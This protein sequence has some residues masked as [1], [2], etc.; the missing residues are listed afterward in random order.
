MNFRQKSVLAGML[1]VGLI[2]TMPAALSAQNEERRA[3]LKIEGKETL[4]LRVLSRAFSSLY[5]D[6]VVSSS[7]IEENLPAFQS[8]YVYGKITP[9]SDL[10]TATWYEVGSDNKGTVRGW[11][12]SDD[13]FEWKQTMCLSY[14][15]PENRQPVLMF[16]SRE[17]LEELTSMTDLERQQAVERFYADIEGGQIPADFPVVTVEPKRAVDISKEFYLLPILEF[18]EIEI[19][20]REGRLLKLAAV[21]GESADA[22]ESSDIRKN[23]DF[24][25]KA[26]LDVNETDVQAL[27]KIGVDVVWVM[28]TTNSMMPYIL[29]TLKVVEDA[30]KQISANTELAETIRFG[31]W[32][33][34][35]SLEIPGID[36]NVNNYTTDLQAIDEFIPTLQ[37]VNVTTVGSEGYA[38]DVFSGIASAVNETN[39]TPDAI[40]LVILVGDAPAHETDHKWNASG[41]N[42]DTLRIIANDRNISIFS[43]HIKDSEAEK[44]HELTEEQ[45]RTLS[46]NR[47]VDSGA[48]YFSTGSDDLQGFEKATK[49]VT[50]SVITFL[51]QIIEQRKQPALVG[52]ALMPIEPGIAHGEPGNSATVDEPEKKVSDL[53][54]TD[55]PPQPASDLRETLDQETASE[56]MKMDVFQQAE[57]SVA[58]GAGSE[59][60]PETMVQAVLKAAL[61]QWI[62]S[63]SGAQAPRDVVA[64]VTDK[65]LISPEMQALEVRLLI[66][67]RQLDSLRETLRTILTA[68]RKEQIS[69]D[70]FFSALQSAAATTARDPDMIKN[71]QSLSQTGLIPEFLAG[72]PYKSRIMDMNSELWNSWSIDEQD[73]FLADLDAR[74]MAYETIHDSPEGWVQLNKD[75]DPSD[76]VYP[77]TLELLP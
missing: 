9:E 31:F 30:S 34:R 69:G 59:P 24:L 10:G 35:D 29:Q 74:I 18:S 16:E 5:A 47:G 71:A 32:G 48:A 21:T 23:P 22:R 40:R 45:F 53:E 20:E 13:V 7:K 50:G 38:E 1:F 27:E 14:T 41:Q 25:K 17:K 64:W 76:Y 68:G 73:M 49:D 58:D 55:S 12:S 43:I 62:G 61:V 57:S 63:Q 39:W 4:P 28:D 70:D 42:Q 2:I 60:T 33:Y 75:D 37:A 19:S 72:L 3:P 6:P 26:V 46:S 52:S 8:F 54:E 51:E 44:F 56:P 77:I 11:M 67:K 15:H 65:D 36:Y 66:N